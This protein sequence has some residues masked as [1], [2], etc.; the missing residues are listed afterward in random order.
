MRDLRD[1]QLRTCCSSAY[2]ADTS[3]TKRSKFTSSTDERTNGKHSKVSVTAFN[4]GQK[5]E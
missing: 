1:S 2:V 3:P 5:N 4:N